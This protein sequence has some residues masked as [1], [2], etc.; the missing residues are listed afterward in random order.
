MKFSSKCRTK[1]LKLG[2]IYT[3]LGS[4]CSFI[5]GTG[6]IFGPKSGLGKSLNSVDSDQ[7]ASSEDS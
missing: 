5:I 4:F 3:I 6:P 7:V 1:K 2:I